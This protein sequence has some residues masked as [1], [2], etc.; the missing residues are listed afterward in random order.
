MENKTVLRPALMWTNYLFMFIWK[1]CFSYFFVVLF[2]FVRLKDEQ[3]TIIPVEPAVA[4]EEVDA[5]PNKI[6]TQPV[7]LEK[8][9]FRIGSL[10]CCYGLCIFDPL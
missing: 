10:S 8:S 4:S 6:L 5:L 7:V 3:A 2:L 9:K 1:S